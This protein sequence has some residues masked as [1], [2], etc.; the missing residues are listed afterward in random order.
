MLDHHQTLLLIKNELRKTQRKPLSPAITLLQ[1]HGVLGSSA[2]FSIDRSID[3]SQVAII[4]K[5]HPPFGQFEKMIQV[6]SALMLEQCMQCV[7][8]ISQTTAAAQAASPQIYLQTLS[9]I[10]NLLQTGD[11]RLMVLSFSSL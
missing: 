8:N 3:E 11:H 4:H 5:D 10:S 6:A 2:S 9:R 7:I 1:A